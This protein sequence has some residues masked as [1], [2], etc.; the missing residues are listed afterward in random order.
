MMLT[1]YTQ[2]SFSDSSSKNFVS[3]AEYAAKGPRAIVQMSSALL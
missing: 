2:I 3:K 1:P